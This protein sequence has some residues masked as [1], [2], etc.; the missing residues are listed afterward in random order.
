MWLWF[1][2][3]SQG[4]RA[5]GWIIII[6]YECINKQDRVFFFFAQVFLIL[7]LNVFLVFFL[8]CFWCVI[9]G[10]F[11]FQIYD[12]EIEVGVVVFGGLVDFFF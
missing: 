7:L 9:Y 5:I 12:L 1:M 11:V 2:C 6:W 4:S 3:D 10:L 8:F